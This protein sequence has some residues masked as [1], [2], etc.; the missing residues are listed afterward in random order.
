M[1][2]VP[3]VTGVLLL[4][5][6]IVL[7]GMYFASSKNPALEANTFL[8]TGIVSIGLSFLFLLMSAR[9]PKLQTFKP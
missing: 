8:I 2:I 6:G 4:L 7:E 3:L 5:A 1:R 9:I